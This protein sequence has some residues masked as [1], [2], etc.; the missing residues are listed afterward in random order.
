MTGK[1]KAPAKKTKKSASRS[2]AATRA[3]SPK[4]TRS[5]APAGAS[6]ATPGRAGNARAS[7]FVT[8]ADAKSAT[9]DSLIRTIEDAELRLSAAKRANTYEELPKL[10]D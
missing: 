9:I 2:M 6:A 4:R 10:L 8:F 3:K 5:A 7:Q 1:R